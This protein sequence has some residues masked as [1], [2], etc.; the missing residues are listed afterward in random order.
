MFS[1]ERSEMSSP[2]LGEA[3]ME[4]MPMER[5]VVTT[6]SIVTM[7]NVSPTTSTTFMYGAVAFITH[8]PRSQ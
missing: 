5:M 1:M 8:F 6:L 2:R 4:F 3:N 7:K